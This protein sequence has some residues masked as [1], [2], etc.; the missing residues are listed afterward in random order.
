MEAST[1]MRQAKKTNGLSE[2]EAP[3]GNL[4]LTRVASACPEDFTAPVPRGRDT[5]FL[6]EKVTG[7][8]PS[9]HIKC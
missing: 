7:I 9:A 4:I 3:Q 8:G 2:T 6:L 5:K 1:K